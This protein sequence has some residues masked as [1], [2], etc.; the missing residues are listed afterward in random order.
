MVYHHAATTP[1]Y[2][3]AWVACSF[4]LFQENKREGNG[5]GEKKVKSGS[6]TEK[7]TSFHE[8]TG[9]LQEYC[10]QQKIDFPN[11]EVLKVGET[12]ADKEK[13]SIPFIPAIPFYPAQNVW[14]PSLPL[15]A[16]ESPHALFK[17]VANHRLIMR[18]GQKGMATGFLCI[19]SCPDLYD[20]LRSRTGETSW[21]WHAVVRVK[22]RTKKVV[23]HSLHHG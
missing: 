17:G 3:L 19:P 15:R 9:L 6:G 13:V 2:H 12:N 1:F 20:L 22:I 7:A 5:K 8:P 21:A 18:Q 16:S 10:Q 4:F 23:Y 14:E 11:L